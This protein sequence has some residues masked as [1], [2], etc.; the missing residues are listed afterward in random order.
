M[1]KLKK[2]NFQERKWWFNLMKKLMLGRYK[3]PKFINQ[4]EKNEK[5]IKI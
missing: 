5:I 4:G 2:N 3:Q 1:A